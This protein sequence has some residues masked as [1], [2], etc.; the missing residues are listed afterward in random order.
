MM[1]W[2]DRS[3]AGPAHY[4]SV[5]AEPLAAGTSIYKGHPLLRITLDGRTRDPTATLTVG[6]LGLLGTVR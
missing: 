6:Y 4:E 2:L 1:W 3:R 5:H